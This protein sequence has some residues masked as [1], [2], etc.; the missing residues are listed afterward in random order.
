MLRLTPAGRAL[1]AGG[2]FTV[3]DA[4]SRA[5]ARRL[6]DTGV[7]HPVADGGGPGPR[8]VTVVVP[9]KDRTEAVARLLAALPAG[10]GG[11]IVVD[12]G[13]ADPEACVCRPHAGASVLRPPPRGP[14]AAR[15]AGPRP[16]RRS[17]P[18]STPTCCPSPAG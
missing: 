17:S 16:R 3:T 1:L 14:A 7:V 4:T 2:G 9:V 11:V 6:L 8:D 13:S 15:N 18:S 12:D 10:L 5:L